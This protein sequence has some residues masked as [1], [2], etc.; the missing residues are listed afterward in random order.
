[1]KVKTAIPAP[2]AAALILGF[3]VLLAPIAVHAQVVSKTAKAGSYTVNLKVLPAESFTGAK[4][5][6]TRDGGAE[7]NLLN[8]PEHPNHHLVA[9]IQQGGKPVENA[10]VSIRYRE[11]PAKMGAWNTLPVV[12]MHVT[13]KSLQTTHFGNNVMLSPGRYEA[14]VT[15]NGSKPATFRFNLKK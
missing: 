15:V 3:G 9:F 5:A 13:G 2:L 12:R 14:S 8:G 6:M 1:M 7:P 10:T 4:A 11:L